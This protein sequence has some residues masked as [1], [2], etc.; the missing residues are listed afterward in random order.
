MRRSAV[1]TYTTILT[2]NL[3]VFRLKKKRKDEGSWTPRRSSFL[4]STI[5]LM[6]CNYI[7]PIVLHTSLFLISG[8]MCDV[9]NRKWCVGFNFQWDGCFIERAWSP[10]QLG[11]WG[12]S[13]QCSCLHW[14]PPGTQVT[15]DSRGRGSRRQ[16]RWLVCQPFKM[17]KTDFLFYSVRLI[18]TI[19]PA[20][21]QW[22]SRRYIG[23]VSLF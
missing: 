13:Q 15:G 16:S 5:L 19:L 7:N 12:M 21:L 3:S 20:C 8:L 2:G 4:L 14:L 9:G 10:G 22:E 23:N 6:K 11:W 1:F 17:W 18:G